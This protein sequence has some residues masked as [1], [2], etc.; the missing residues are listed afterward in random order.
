MSATTTKRLNELGHL[1]NGFGDDALGR[2]T[3]DLIDAHAPSDA[4]EL[5]G[6]SPDDLRRM[7]R[8]TANME[9]RLRTQE[10]LLATTI[11]KGASSSATSLPNRPGP[12]AHQQQ[13]A[14]GSAGSFATIASPTSAHSAPGSFNLLASPPR[15]SSALPTTSSASSAAQLNLAQ[16]PL[17]LSGNAPLP[18]AYD[19]LYQPG[20][21]HH[22]QAAL[23]DFIPPSGQVVDPLS[24]AGIG[25]GYLSNDA[26]VER[27]AGELM[28]MESKRPPRESRKRPSDAALHPPSGRIKRMKSSPTAEAESSKPTANGK[29]KKDALNSPS[30]KK[31]SKVD[32]GPGTSSGANSKARPS[33][34]S[35][36]QKK[37]NHIQSEQKR[38]ANIRRGYDALCA[39]VPAL[40][41]ETERM[42][43]NAS[44]K[45]KDKARSEGLVLSKT[46]EHIHY[47][48][49]QQASL[50]QRLISA[51]SVRPHALPQRHDAPWERRW[52]GGRG[53]MVGPNGEILE[54]DD[55][56]DG[57]GDAMDEDGDEDDDE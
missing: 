48:L 34:L 18:S 56:G 41:E 38:R 32:D 26:D 35:A 27:A 42:G 29:S 6:V 36:D 40:R 25:D 12:Y 39:S 16:S 4:D 50:T 9:Q 3:R 51:R 30:K 10:L 57:D 20:P 54:P 49:A 7:L 5:A 47:L 8:D 22:Q 53:V 13:Q 21:H 11:A 37:A 1:L 15:V 33:L 43:L 44:D 23:A 28:R 2:T 52:D 45:D 46:I 31:L 55:D 17:G 24:G 14:S 19:T